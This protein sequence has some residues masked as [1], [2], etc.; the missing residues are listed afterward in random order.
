MRTI[1]P[2]EARVADQ[3]PSD[4]GW[5]FE[6]KW[7]GFRCIASRNAGRV[8]LRA[9]S[10]KSLTRYFP[11]VTAMI[12]SLA[13]DNFVLDGELTIVR[14]EALSFDAL[15]A[16]LHPA[17]SRIRKLSAETP[18]C[19]ILFDMPVAPGG[20]A[21][22]DAPLRQRRAALEKFY[23]R[24][25]RIRS[26]LLTPYTRDLGEARKWLSRAGGSL[27]GI[28]AKR[29][30]GPYLSGERAIVKVKCLRTAG[31]VVGGF[32]Y[33]EGSNEVASL[34][35]GL[36]DS[37]GR[38][39]HVGFASGLASLDRKALTA[40]L[41]KLRGGAGFTGNAPGGPSRWRTERSAEWV[42]LR[43]KLV[44]EVRYDHVTGDRF[45]HGTKF[46]RWRPDKAPRQCTFDQL[47]SEADAAVLVREVLGRPTLE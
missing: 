33:G 30:D 42:P 44:A 26:L 18:A 27:D 45:R 2:M 4:L 37:C 43:T 39:D 25:R 1:E 9:K 28:I 13:D 3:L 10:G 35:L 12:S 22:F 23:R 47:G 17:E 20:T 31:C 5:Q 34:L 14:H 46:L 16:R 11:E 29:L 7:D 38:L 41:R 19:F 8:D 15:Q 6:P 36:Y 32:R 40:Q 21:L 24:F